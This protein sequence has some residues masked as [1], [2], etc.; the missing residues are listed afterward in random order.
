MSAPSIAIPYEKQSEQLTGRSCG[1]ACLSMAYRSLGKEVTQA[2]IWPAIS[3]ANRSGLI[4]STTHLMALDARN[5]GLSAVAIQARH[6]LQV[7]RI[8]RAVGIRAVINHRVRRDSGSGHY[9]VLVDIDSKE[10]VLHDPLFGAARRLSHAELVELWLSHSPNSEVTGGVLIAIGGSATPA[11][12]SCEFCHTPMP[13]SVDCPRCGQP[14]GMQPPEVLGCI[15]DGCI[16]RMWNWLCCP[17]CDYVFTLDAG[18]ATGT[19]VEAA[20]LPAPEAGSAPG[21]DIAKLFEAMDKFT[22]HML[23]IPAAA[24]NPD[25][26]KQIE[27]ITGSKETFR[28]AY[29]EHVARRTAVL[30][31]LAA[32][33]EKAKQQEEA[34]LK[35]TE[36][37]KA[38]SRPLDGNVLGRALLKNLRFIA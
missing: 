5:R 1:A 26:K 17:A 13:P 30:G 24:A 23:S 6:P 18:A 15:K 8:C 20:P 16:A 7:L 25:V 33:T 3:K 4:S 34:K 28:A 2:E 21:V 38:P 27:I 37:P 10:V 9:S 14:T 35:K 12:P 32:L 19:R 29:A 36:E 11:T 22:A 31:Q